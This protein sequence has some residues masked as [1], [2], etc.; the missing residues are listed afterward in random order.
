MSKREEIIH[1]GQNSH[2]YWALYNLNVAFSDSMY[3][4]SSFFR[5]EHC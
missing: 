3:K 5:A 4:G 1:I 2:A